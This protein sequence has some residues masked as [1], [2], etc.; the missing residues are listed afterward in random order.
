MNLSAPLW[1]D[2]VQLIGSRCGLFAPALRLLER[3]LIETAPLIHASF[4]LRDGLA[5]FAA[6]LGQLKVLVH[7]RH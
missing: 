4:N 3:H 6:A 2:E 7:H 1:V 5:A